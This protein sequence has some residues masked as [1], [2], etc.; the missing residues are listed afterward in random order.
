[1]PAE[2]LR[3]MSAADDAFDVAVSSDDADAVA[4]PIDEDA[5]QQ[6]LTDGALA[7]K[8]RTSTYLI[9]ATAVSWMQDGSR[10]T[11]VRYFRCDAN[12]FRV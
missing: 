6:R 5:A 8:R 7:A 9:L 3:T 10:R 2:T 11:H 12:E 4:L 1:M